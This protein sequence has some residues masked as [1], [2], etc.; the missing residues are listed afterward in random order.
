MDLDEKKIITIL[1]MDDKIREKLLNEFDSYEPVRRAAL[2]KVLWDTYDLLYE[3]KLQQNLQIA[4]EKAK[5]NEEKLD[6][7]FYAR[8]HEQTQKDMNKET[9]ETGEVNELEHLRAKLHTLSQ[10]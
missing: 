9:L 7:D 3:F 1:P 5:K 4:F 2:S 6:E 10:G 8:V